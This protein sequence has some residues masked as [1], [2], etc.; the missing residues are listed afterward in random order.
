VQPRKVLEDMLAVIEKLGMPVSE[1][2]RNYFFEGVKIIRRPA[3]SQKSE[4]RVV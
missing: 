4:L 2:Q 1:K 3:Q